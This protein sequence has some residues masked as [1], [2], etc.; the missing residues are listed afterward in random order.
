MNQPVAHTGTFAIQVNYLCILMTTAAAETNEVVRS[1]PPCLSESSHGETGFVIDPQ[2]LGP[3]P[4]QGEEVTCANTQ[5]SAEPRLA[6]QHAKGSVSHQQGTGPSACE[7]QRLLFFSLCGSLA[8]FPWRMFWLVL[9][10]SK[11]APPC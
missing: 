6:S 2:A 9:G 11:T 5:F 8:V 7:L 1:H 10:L 4:G 3:L